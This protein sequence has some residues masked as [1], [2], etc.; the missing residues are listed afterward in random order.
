MKIQ[1]PGAG[2]A[3]INDFTQLSRVGRLFGV[4]MPGLEVRPL[5]EELRN[6]VVEELD[7]R[8]EASSQE[9]FAERL[10]G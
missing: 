5:L 4:L 3:L 9:A 8:L 10:R 1:Y 6:R 7:Y 2:Q